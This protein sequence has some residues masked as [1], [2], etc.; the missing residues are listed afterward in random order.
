[1]TKQPLDDELPEVQP[2]ELELLPKAFQAYAED[3]AELMQVPLEF[4]GVPL[5]AFAGSTIGRQAGVFPQRLTKWVEFPNFWGGL[6]GSP[7]LKKSAA[8][9]AA[10]RPF[11]KLAERAQKEY[12]K[13]RLYFEA[14]KDVLEVTAKIQK[15]KFEKKLE[16]LFTHTDDPEIP[17][18]PDLPTAYEPKLRRYSCA[19]VTQEALVD[20]LAVNP[21][22]IPRGE[23]RACNALA[24][25]RGEGAA[26]R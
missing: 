23:G 14:K 1:M 19:Q 3:C 13:E 5:M 2:F 24:A 10:G 6:I 20:L 17:E 26:E 4:I 11:R 25:Y 12:E 21:R 7:G 15:K 18:G 16:E 22:G 9:A 8:I